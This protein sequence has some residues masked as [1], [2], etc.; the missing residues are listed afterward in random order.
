MLICSL[1]VI[2]SKNSIHSVLYLVLVFLISVLLFIVVGAEFLALIVL[3]IY[4]GAISVLFL[5]LVMLFDDRLSSLFNVMHH[6]L[7]IGFL[8]CFI[9]FMELI[10][11]IDLNYNSYIGNYQASY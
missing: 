10:L 4:V 5:F 2:L 9:F 3:I 1:L 8:I 11:L 7:P 6:Y